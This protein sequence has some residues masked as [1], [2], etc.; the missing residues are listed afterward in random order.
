MET[1]VECMVKKKANGLMSA[2]KV[3]LIGIAVITGLLGFM[4]LIVFLIIAVVAGVGAYFV[5]LN[6]NLEYEYLY[7]DKQ[8]TVDKIMARTR[9]K[10]V[11]TFDLERME[12]LAPIKSWHLD[13]Y[14]NR[15]L[16]VVDYSSGVEQQ[17]DIRYSMIYNGEKRVIFEPNAEM[18]AAIKSIAPRKV[19]TD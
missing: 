8:L 4:G 19:F 15:Q 12:I 5:S 16:K 11:E 7:V 17:P 3:L 2:L 14:K 1:Y 10:K 9:R 6:A 18:V 13:D